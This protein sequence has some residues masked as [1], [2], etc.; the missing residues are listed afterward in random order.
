M[1]IITISGKARHGKDS[2]A[3]YVEDFLMVRGNSC[4]IIHYADFLKYILKQYFQ[5]DGKKDEQGRALLQNVGTNIVR[6]RNPNFWIEI[7][8]SMINAIFYNYDYIIIPDT[9][10]PNEIDYWKDKNK[11][12][13]CIRVYRPEVDIE[14]Q[15]TEKA[16]LHES[17]TA[18]DN[19]IF[20]YVIEA[21]NLDELRLGIDKIMRGVFNEG[22][23]E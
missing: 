9:R 4:I 12:L 5:W 2:A 21:N 17:E 14:D 16:K 1:Q 3:L 15:L 13:T 23:C 7:V 20:D 19:Y 22:V 8:D 18:L 11:L 10:F 6:K